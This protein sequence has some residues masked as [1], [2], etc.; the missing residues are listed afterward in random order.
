LNCLCSPAEEHQT[1]SR[2]GPRRGRRA[3][4]VVHCPG[5][6]AKECLPHHGSSD[7]SSC[8]RSPID[9][10]RRVSLC[11]EFA[12]PASFR[13]EGPNAQRL[14]VRHACGAAARPRTPE[15]VAEWS[16]NGAARSVA[17]PPHDA[18]CV[19]LR[20]VSCI[21]HGNT[22]V[23][24]RMGLLGLFHDRADIVDLV[25]RHYHGASG[26]GTARFDAAIQCVKYGQAGDIIAAGAAVGES[27]SSAHNQES[28][29]CAPGRSKGD[30]ILPYVRV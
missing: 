25:L 9:V 18:V 1:R 19:P 3:E 21:R 27:I 14:S 13:G 20:C 23:V 26:W 12:C 22:C 15:R 2:R 30:C 11:A 16:L 28:K 7:S 4:E 8:D 17:P 10:M 5:S 24:L 6:Q 29:L